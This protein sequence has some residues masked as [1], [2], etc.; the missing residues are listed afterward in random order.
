ML[1]KE[2]FEQKVARIVEGMRGYA[3]NL[4]R[5]E[6][7][8]QDLMQDTALLALQAKD[9]FVVGTNIGAWLTTI[10]KNRFLSQLR[11]KR[12]V[13][14]ED[15]SYA[16]RLSVQADEGGADEELTRLE[17]AMGSLSPQRREAVRRVADGESYEEVARALGMSVGTV[18][19]SVNRGREQLAMSLGRG[20]QE[21]RREAG[22]VRA[23]SGHLK[24][25]N[26][27]ERPGLR[28]F[29]VSQFHPVEPTREPGPRP[30]LR[31]VAI[32]ELW[33]D[34]KYQR[35]VLGKGMTNIRSIAANFDWRKF[36]AVCVAEH[37]GTCYVV[38]GQHRTYAALLRGITEVPCLVMRSSPAEAASA[39]A[40]INGSVTQIHALNVFGAKVA[41]GDEEAVALA[42]AC[43]AEGVQIKHY[44]VPMMKLRPGQT[45]ALGTLQRG[46]RDLGEEKLRLA[47]RLIMTAHPGERSVLSA[48]MV[49]AALGVVSVLPEEGL[50]SA[51]RG[52]SFM[53]AHR[54][55]G[56][57][58]M[59]EAL[60]RQF[61]ERT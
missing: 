41:A 22:A 12:E 23:S 3:L 9:R 60:I 48:P 43:R 49:R 28:C 54:D 32:K 35:S 34:E 40:A 26:D 17:K 4:T 56:S 2:P 25:M 61:R 51:A 24:I 19:S 45:I 21:E 37:E 18:K 31:W 50:V 7:A 55:H 20:R 59:T 8:A 58:G 42:R 29:D 6:A 13:E 10:M 36:T 46:L 57:R 44:P 5:N 39:F 15:G 11:K 14:D 53:D 38:D 33:I 16:A 47:L 27:E 30:E 1:D 52:I